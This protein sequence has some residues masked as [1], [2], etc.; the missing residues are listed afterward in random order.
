MVHVFT[1]ENYNDVASPE[2]ALGL[3][4]SVAHSVPRSP[5]FKQSRMSSQ[6][7]RCGGLAFVLLLFAQYYIFA[8]V[9]TVAIVKAFDTTTIQVCNSSI[10]QQRHN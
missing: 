5:A 9:G 7:R 10:V 6:R 4:T 2:S 8:F 1:R 3:N